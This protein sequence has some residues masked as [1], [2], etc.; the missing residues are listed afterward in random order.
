MPNNWPH[1]VSISWAMLDSDS[2]SIMRASS[3]IIKP[4]G[5][6]IPAESTNIHGITQ[7][8]AEEYGLPLKDVLTKFLSEECDVIIAHNAYF[9]KNVFMQAMVWD[10]KVPFDGFN[11]PCKCS[12]LASKFM[13]KIPNY[14]K[15]G[16]FKYPKLSELYLHVM[17]DVPK[18]HHLHSSLYDTLFLCE[19]INKSEELRNR[20][21]IASTNINN[22]GQVHKPKANKNFAS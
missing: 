13:C 7:A 12:M 21:G 20:L 16:D 22:E 2:R 19:V 10:L 1:M 14:S 4:I 6:T 9:D 17:K 8:Q 3:Y 15:F 5:W 11:R 18:S